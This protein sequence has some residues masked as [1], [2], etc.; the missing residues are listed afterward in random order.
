MGDIDLSG[1]IK[2]IRM[3]ADT[4]GACDSATFFGSE[5]GQAASVPSGGTPCFYVDVGL[6]GSIPEDQ[7]EYPIAFNISTTS[8]HQLLD[9]DPNIPQ[10]QI[11]DAIAAGCGPWYQG[12]DFIQAPLCP[13]PQFDLHPASAGSMAELGSQ[14]MRQDTSDIV[15]KSARAGIQLPLLQRQEQPEL[16]CG[17]RA[18]CSW[19]PVGSELLER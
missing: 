13:E 15:R 7:D 6:Q 14:D 18:G 12:H 11:D 9:C 1:S 10:G 8:Q 19:L 3:A 17:H 16:S 4:N 5:T 2:W